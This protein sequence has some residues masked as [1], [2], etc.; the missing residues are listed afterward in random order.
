M[1]R[2]IEVDFFPQAFEEA[3]EKPRILIIDNNG[4][5]TYSAK[6]APRDRAFYHWFDA[7]DPEEE[8]L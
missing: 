5:F 2:T 8:R 4:D 1:S 6:F 7:Y 3:K